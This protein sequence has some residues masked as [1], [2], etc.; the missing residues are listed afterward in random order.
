MFEQQRFEEFSSL[1]SGIHGNI[2]KLKARYTTQLGLKG[3]HV[4]WIYLLRTHPEG[5]SASQLAA[6]EGSSR[7][8][9]SR[10]IDYLF[11]RGIIFTEEAGD[12]RRYGWKLKLTDEG[13]K[14]SNIIAAVVADI[15]KTVSHEIPEEDLIVFYRTL[16]TLAN[17]FANLEQH[18][19]IQ[20]VIDQ[21]QS[22]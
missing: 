7:S 2:Q 16:E 8:L 5:L 3:V 12:K 17:S 19:D 1:I 18:N 21:C 13:R 4:F 10:E 11:D 20:E 9:V 6:A 14:I 15:Q 22:S